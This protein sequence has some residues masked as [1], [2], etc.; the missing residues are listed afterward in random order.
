MQTHNMH[1]TQMY[2]HTLAPLRASSHAL[3]FLFPAQPFEIA[4][5][6]REPACIRVCMHAYCL[7]EIQNAQHATFHIL[8]IKFWFTITGMTS[9]LY[10]FREG[11]YLPNYCDQ[12]HTPCSLLC[13]LFTTCTVSCFIII[14]SFPHLGIFFSDHLY[15]AG[16]WASC[17]W[18]NKC[19]NR[20]LACC[21]NARDRTAYCCCLFPSKDE[22]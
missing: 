8:L 14:V 9:C 1:V 17:W 5:F 10:E 7:P 16:G 20:S 18:S 6:G 4:V 15:R 3:L 13:P 11:D 19:Q 12:T 2:I 22:K 21:S